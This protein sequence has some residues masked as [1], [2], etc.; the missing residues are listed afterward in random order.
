MRSMAAHLPSS[1][2]N[3]PLPQLIVA[4]TDDLEHRWSRS[5]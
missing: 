1:W 5:T 3:K 4:F 2:A